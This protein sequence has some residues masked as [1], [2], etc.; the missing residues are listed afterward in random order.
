VTT[1]A[2]DSTTACA[3]LSRHVARAGRQIDNEHVQVG[4]RDAAREL[5]HRLRHHRPPPDGRRSLAEKE[6]EADYRKAVCLEGHDVLVRRHAHARRAILDAEQDRKAW[7]VDVRVEQRR[8]QSVSRERQ[9]EIHRD[10]ALPHA[11]LSRADGDDVPGAG[12]VNLLGPRITRA[13]PRRL[14][15][16]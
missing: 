14:R 13:A 11:A 2:P 4:P 10:G 16:R 8:P 15:R 1:I 7:S 12:K 6:A 3:R 5:L 9:R